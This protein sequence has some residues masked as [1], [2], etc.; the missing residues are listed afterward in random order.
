[1]CV[2]VR[3]SLL[4]SHNVAWHVGVRR[5]AA[6]SLSDPTSTPT[7]LP[8]L[9]HCNRNDAE[10]ALLTN[11]RFLLFQEHSMLKAG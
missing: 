10:F 3:R 11:C 5:A 8:P 1:M 7:P 2:Y 6:C 4:A 9:L